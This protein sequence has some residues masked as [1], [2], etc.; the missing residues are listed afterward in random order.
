MGRRFRNGGPV[1]FGDD[2]HDCAAKLR[3]SLD[4]VVWFLDHGITNDAILES[5]AHLRA[6]IETYDLARWEQEVRRR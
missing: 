2:N 4:T 1:N 6:Q 3:I 5:E